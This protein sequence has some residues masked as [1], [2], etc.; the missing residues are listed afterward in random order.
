MAS[1]RATAVVDYNSDLVRQNW[2]LEGLLQ[3]NSMSFTAS[4]TGGSSNSIVYQE[5]NTNAKDGHTVVFDFDGNLTGRAV[6]GKQTATGTGETKKKFSDKITVERY[7]WVVDNGDKFDGVN[8]GD[9]SITE[10][11]DS[12]AKLSDLWIR[13]K[14]QAILDVAQQSATHRLIL[15]KTFTFDQFL[16]V[17]NVVKTGK[18]YVKMDSKNSAD[19]RRPLKPFMLQNGSPV[20]LFVVDNT[21]KNMLLK[22][23]GAQSVFSGGDVRGNDNRLFKGVIGKMGNFLFVE[24]D[25]FFGTTNNTAK[26]GDFVDEYGYLQFD[27]TEIEISG[28]RQYTGDDNLFVPKSWTGESVAAPGAKTFSRGLILGAGAI[29]FGMGKLP[30]YKW[31]ESHDFGITSESCMEAWI[32]A[33]ATILNPESGD[34][35]YAKMGGISHGIVAV[36]IQVD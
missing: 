13:I 9:L 19:I 22:T 35:S 31:Q 29:Q 10:H 18:G 21:M 25:T 16:D 12:R 30:D 2:M 3:A 36:D 14:D 6:K 32:G 24:A 26:P 1:N 23:T 27:K 5:V 7:R 33:K 8:I 17:E 34:Y 4:Y 20:W 11:A 15:D 28:L